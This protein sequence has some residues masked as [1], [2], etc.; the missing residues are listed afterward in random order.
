MDN[1]GSSVGGDSNLHVD[2][3]TQ[4]VETARSGGQA[5]ARLAVSD[6]VDVIKVALAPAD[7]RPMTIPERTESLERRIGE[8]ELIAGV[9]LV[10]LAFVWL[11]R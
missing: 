11:R 1:D 4:S 8:M 2:S 6:L 3:I 5:I 9:L 7:K 10:L